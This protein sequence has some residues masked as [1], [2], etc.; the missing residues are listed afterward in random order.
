MATACCSFSDYGDDMPPGRYVVS[1]WFE[2][3]T[4]TIYSLYGG[5]PVSRCVP[6]LRSAVVVLADED[7]R[8]SDCRLKAAKADEQAA[9]LRKFHA[10]QAKRPSVQL[11][12]DLAERTDRDGAPYY[13]ASYC[14]VEAEPGDTP[15]EAFRNFDRL[16]MEGRAGVWE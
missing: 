11:P 10:E 6:V 8:I 4:E 13:V 7:P 12:A 14:G 1:Y 9:E 3:E 5:F 16:W 2:T 15:R